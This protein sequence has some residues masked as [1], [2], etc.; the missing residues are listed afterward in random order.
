LEHGTDAFDERV[1]RWWRRGVLGRTR[2]KRLREAR[3]GREEGSREQRAWKGKL[4]DELVG[5]VAVVERAKHAEEGRLPQPD[6]P[7]I[8]L[9]DPRSKLIVT[10]V[11]TE[12][13]SDPDERILESC[14]ISTNASIAY[15][16]N[17]SRS[18]E[19]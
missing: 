2:S 17:P 8:A 19:R 10:S 13:A 4:V 9:N 3:I 6:G 5:V 18:R 7:T 15:L 12:V 14:L 16:L 11:S 1:G